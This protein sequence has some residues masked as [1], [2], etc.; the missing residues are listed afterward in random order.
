MSLSLIYGR[1]KRASWIGP[2]FSYHFKRSC[3]NL[4]SDST[5]YWPI[6][7]NSIREVEKGKSICG[8]PLEAFASSVILPSAT[9]AS[10]LQVLVPDNALGA[11]Q[12]PTL[13]Q[14]SWLPRLP[15]QLHRTGTPVPLFKQTT[16]AP[17]PQNPSR[18]PCPPLQTHPRKKRRIIC[19]RYANLS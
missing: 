18:I 12:P 7:Q 4:L 6:Y 5:H 1:R 9:S 16:Q 15:P 14:A 2:K 17:M 8:G 13:I 11:C 19:R 10:S 3:D